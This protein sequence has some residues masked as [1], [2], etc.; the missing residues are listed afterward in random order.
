MNHD[1]IVS[2]IAE[3]IAPVLRPDLDAATYA[4]GLWA[5]ADERGF[6]E[7]RGTHTKTGEPFTLWGPRE[8]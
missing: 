4:E 1:A 3:R 2:E 8:S 7:V 6:M 5:E